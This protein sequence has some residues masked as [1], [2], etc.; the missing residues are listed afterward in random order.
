MGSNAA[1]TAGDQNYHL[2]TRTRGRKQVNGEILKPKKLLQ[3]LLAV[4]DLVY[5]S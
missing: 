2:Y 1:N 5:T 3:N 4:L